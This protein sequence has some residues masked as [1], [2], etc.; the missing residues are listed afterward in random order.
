MLETLSKPP[1]AGSV[2][3]RGSDSRGEKPRKPDQPPMDHSLAPLFF[4]AK[5]QSKRHR[6][7]TT[8]FQNRQR[9]P[10]HGNKKKDWVEG[11][12]PQ[13][14]IT[15]WLHL[16]S[17]LQKSVCQIGSV[18]FDSFLFNTSADRVQ[19]STLS[20]TNAALT[21]CKVAT[22]TFLFEICPLPTHVE[23]PSLR[24]DGHSLPG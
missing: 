15:P 7:P 20:A 3:T 16:S 18:G 22:R 14:G 9:R 13:L 4:F 24:D 6:H 19:M 11:T 21:H 10:T 23:V 5:T 2:A 12:P 1:D 17:F 8:S